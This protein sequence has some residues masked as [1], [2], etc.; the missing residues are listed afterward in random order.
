MVDSQIILDDRQWRHFLRVVKN[1]LVN[2]FELLKTGAMTYGFRD[3][4]EHFRKEESPK[5]KWKKRKQSTQRAYALRGKYDK[6]YN[7][8]NRLLQLTGKLRNSVLPSS[9]SIAKKG[10]YGILLFTDVLYA[11]R[12]NK[13]RKFMWLSGSAT[14]KMVDLIMKKVAGKW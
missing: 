5:G 4:I 11:E 9:G 1:N 3:I 8:S 14:Q 10:K 6:R 13:K 12:Q 7:P 2:P